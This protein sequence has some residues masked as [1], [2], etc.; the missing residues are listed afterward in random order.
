[1]NAN[2]AK[3][4][5]VAGSLLG[6]P[7]FR[8]DFGYIFEGQAVISAP[9][10]AAFNAASSIGG[11]LGCI[12]GGGIADTSGRRWALGFCSIISISAVTVEVFAT[13]KVTLLIGKVCEV[14]AKLKCAQSAD[15]TSVG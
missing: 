13:A 3:S 4:K 6:A 5:Q 7:Q 14:G 10:L 9:W 1:M 2:I 11:L 12:L 8:K 15:S